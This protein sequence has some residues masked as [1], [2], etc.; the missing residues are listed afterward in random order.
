MK[1]AL[2][3]V[4]VVKAPKR[5]F[6]QVC[7]SV[8]IE[9]QVSIM[10]HH[11]TISS[12]SIDL[13]A[14]VFPTWLVE[15]PTVTLMHHRCQPAGTIARYE[16]CDPL[17]TAWLTRQAAVEAP[18]HAISKD[19]VQRFLSLLRLGRGMTSSTI[20]FHPKDQ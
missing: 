11:V 10:H 9:V 20:N 5:T 7:I 16:T 12:S 13:F 2:K 6:L 8:L 17:L 19:I 15:F 3:A 4:N 14:E 1:K 18:L